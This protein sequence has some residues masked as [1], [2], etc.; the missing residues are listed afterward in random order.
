MSQGG[1]DGKNVE[2][3]LMAGGTTAATVKI[4]SDALFSG[5][6]APLL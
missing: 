6:S 1:K 2:L 4:D 3:K 5:A